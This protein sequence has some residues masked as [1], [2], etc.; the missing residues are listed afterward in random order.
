MHELVLLGWGKDELCQFGHGKGSVK[1]RC[2]FCKRGSE[3]GTAYVLN[4]RLVF[5]SLKLER[6]V[7]RLGHEI[8]CVVCSECVLVHQMI[9][10]Q[11]ANTSE[12]AVGELVQN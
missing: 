1:L 4:G 7:L 9:S 3:D 11:G 2:Y 10:L 12:A 8:C 5:R 6:F